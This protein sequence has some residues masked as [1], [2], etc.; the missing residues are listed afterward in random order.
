MI[1]IIQIVATLGIGGAEKMVVD[2]ATHL[3]RD[4]YQVKVVAV[5]RGGILAEKLLQQGI[6]VKIIGKSTKLGL[7]TLWRLYQYLKAEQPDIIHT[8]LFGADTYGRLAAWLAR[9][10]GKPIIISTEHSLNYQ[11]GKIKKWLKYRLAKVTQRIVAVSQAAK[12]Y[13]VQ[14]EKIE[15]NKISVIHNGVKMAK[16]EKQRQHNRLIIGSISR[17]ERD[18]GYTYL[19]KA[20]D[21]IRELNWECWLVGDGADRG[22][23]EDLARRSD[24][25]H[26]IKFF[27]WQLDIKRYLEQMDIFVLPSLEEGLSIALIEAGLAG[28]PVVATRVGGIPEVVLPNQTGILVPAKDEKNLAQALRQLILDPEL[29]KSLGLQ[30]QA[31]TKEKF[32]LE[33]MISEYQKLYESFIS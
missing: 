31:L 7:G 11:E 23:L 27:G 4:K 26:R 22:R 10:D 2:L 8:H 24:L 28:L 1:K 15:P 21:R 9:R 30:G 14:V 33:T 32:G 18:K 13:S 29:R 3:P 19:I 6:E 20:L 17:L 5:V 25:D 16:L 12:G